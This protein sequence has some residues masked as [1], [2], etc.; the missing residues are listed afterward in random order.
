MHPYLSDLISRI[1]NLTAKAQKARKGKKEKAT[2]D[3]SLFVLFAF[4][5]K[6]REAKLGASIFFDLILR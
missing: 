2:L 6:E 5:D 4:T 3:A 1:K